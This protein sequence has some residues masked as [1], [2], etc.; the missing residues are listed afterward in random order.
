[1][2][3]DGEDD[4]DDDDEDYEHAGI[5]THLPPRDDATRLFVHPP[6]ME[7]KIH[8]LEEFIASNPDLAPRLVLQL[9]EALGSDEPADEVADV[10]A[11]HPEAGERWYRFRSDRIHDLIDRWLA[12]HQVAVVEEPPWR[13]EGGTP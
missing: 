9:R 2:A 1:V 11:D 8:W 3:L 5:D 6:D 7:T 10:F 12:E 4:V 13:A